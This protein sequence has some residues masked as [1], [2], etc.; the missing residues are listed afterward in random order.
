MIN[1]MFDIDGTLTP[2]RLPIDKDFEVFLKQWILNKQ[3]YLVTGSD[4]EK[5]IEQIGTD[6]WQSVTKVYQ[7]CGNQVWRNGKLVKEANFH[8]S[9]SMQAKLDTF[10]KSSN[11]KEKCGNHIE[12]RVGLV[13]FSIIGRNCSQIQREAYYKWDKTHQERLKICN[14]LMK[15]F[16]EIEAS[17]GGQISIDIYQK[18]K[19]KAQV[20]DDIDGEIYF[21]GDKMEKGGNDYPIA[22]RLKKDKRKYKLF[23][24]NSP[25]ETW[26]IL[27]KIN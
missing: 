15:N 9:D 25:E 23:K 2:S 18:G 26:E 8:L 14:N 1:Y 11:W 7:S 20:L 10:L 13:N 24:V 16:P 21:F 12:Q 5:T 27:K 3:T 22:D 6:L 4:K 19:N 17:I